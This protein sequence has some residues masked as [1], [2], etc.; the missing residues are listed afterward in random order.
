ME[1]YHSFPSVTFVALTVGQSVE[2]GV[3]LCSQQNQ[4]SHDS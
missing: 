2:H 4:D 1:F 3:E